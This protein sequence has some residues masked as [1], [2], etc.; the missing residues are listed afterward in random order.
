[1][2]RKKA[3]RT[4]RRPHAREL[5][6]HLQQAAALA[7]PG[8]VLGRA[9]GRDQPPQARRLRAARKR[10]QRLQRRLVHRAQQVRMPRQRRAQ[11]HG[12]CAR[13]DAP[14]T[15][16][17]QH[18]RRQQS[19]QRATRRRRAAA[20][21]LATAAGS[22]NGPWPGAGGASRYHRTTTAPL[23]SCGPQWRAMFVPPRPPSVHASSPRQ[24]QHEQP[25][26]L[27]RP[28]ARRRPAR[29]SP[30]A[31]TGGRR[32]QLVRVAVRHAQ[33]EHGVQREAQRARRALHHVRAILRAHAHLRA[34][35]R[36]PLSWPRWDVL[37]RLPGWPR[38]A[39]G[40]AAACCMAPWPRAALATRAVALRMTP[41]RAAPGAGHSLASPK[42]DSPGSR[43]HPRLCLN[44]G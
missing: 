24:T 17:P 29:C 8:L 9:V 26:A 43:Q 44:V 18:A 10:G 33:P 42:H 20:R 28:C 12:A 35:R 13:G 14:I 30:G 25:Q 36:R 15:M 7:V 3:R 21:S 37:R 6:Q 2:E 31:R 23:P 38:C 41:G 34:W 19:T 27:T 39:A 32:D 5:L 16:A 22:G 11:R 4:Q 40:L 1:M